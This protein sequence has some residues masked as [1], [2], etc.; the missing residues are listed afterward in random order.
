MCLWNVL[1]LEILTICLFVEADVV[2]LPETV[3][4]VEQLCSR[5]TPISTACS[6]K[7]AV[8]TLP[9]KAY[10]VIDPLSELGTAVCDERE[11]RRA[12]GALASQWHTALLD[13]L[14]RAVAFGL[15]FS[16][17]A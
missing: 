14:N 7:I 2:V 17:A 9:Q 8:P 12:A 5:S 6:L 11:F 4:A 3:W 15:D 10:L 16:K 13:K 1:S